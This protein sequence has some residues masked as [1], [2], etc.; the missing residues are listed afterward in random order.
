MLK[1]KKG[2]GNPSWLLVLVGV[3]NLYSKDGVFLSKTQVS[4]FKLDYTDQMFWS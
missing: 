4:H 1:K 2:G 3:I